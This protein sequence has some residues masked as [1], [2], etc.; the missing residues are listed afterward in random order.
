MNTLRLRNDSGA[1]AMLAVVLAVSSGRVSGQGACVPTFTGFGGVQQIAAFPSQFAETRHA[2]GDLN[3]DGY[4]DLIVSFTEISSPSPQHSVSVHLGSGGA[5]FGPAQHFPSGPDPG[6][7]SIGDFN[8]DGALDV[9]VLNR[10]VGTVS[11][12]LGDGAGGLGAPVAFPVGAGPGAIVTHDL[13]GDGFLD[14]IVTNRG[15]NSVSILFGLGT[16]AFAGQ[17]TALVGAQPV[18]V[19]VDDFNSD[20]VPDIVTSNTAGDSLSILLS[21]GVAGFGPVVTFSLGGGSQPNSVVSGDFDSDGNFDLAVVASG[22]VQVLLG[23]GNGF[24]AAPQMFTAGFGPSEIM[25]ADFDLDGYLD[26][27]VTNT[28]SGGFTNGAVTVLLG[29]GDGTFAVNGSFAGTIFNWPGIAVGDVDQDGAMDICMTDV[30]GDVNWIRNLLGASPPN[31]FSMLSPQDGADKLPIPDLISPWPGG[32]AFTPVS[33]TDACGLNVTYS[34]TIAT[35]PA[36]SQIVLTQT[37]IV[38]TQFG[39]PTGVLLPAST[40][41]WSVSATNPNGSVTAS[42]PVFE[43]STGIPADLNGDGVVDGTDLLILLNSW[44]PP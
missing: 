11:V 32:S 17:L 44:T 12:L 5:V 29:A 28:T 31:G 2:L 18:G 3:A 27:V 37:G 30:F 23:G 36:L 14:L 10:T 21:N 22:A 13:N 8:R 1:A 43:F 39:I 19:V 35:D 24:F 20:G 15:S 26:L 41:Y 33:W 9:A 40:Y 7:L 42:P 4:L 16:G 6:S 25:S 34:L 38:G